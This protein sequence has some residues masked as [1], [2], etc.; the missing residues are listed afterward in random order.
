MN[1]SASEAPNASNLTGPSVQQLANIRRIHGSE[2]EAPGVPAI[3]NELVD[4]TA[5]RL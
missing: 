2:K 4:Q 1:S 5:S 3:E